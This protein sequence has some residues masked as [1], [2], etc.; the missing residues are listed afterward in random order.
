MRNRQHQVTKPFY[1]IVAGLVGTLLLSCLTGPSDTWKTRNAE[2]IQ[3]HGLK[4]R[5]RAIADVDVVPSLQPGKVYEFTDL[6]VID[7][8]SGVRATIA[9][10]RGA[11]VE[12]VEMAPGALYPEEI[13]RAELISVVQEGSAICVLDTG[14]LELSKNA[15]VY[16]TEGTKHSLRAGPNGCK[17]IEVFS[18]VRIDHLNLAG[19]ELSEGANTSFPDQTAEPSLQPGR[20]YDLN[21]IPFTPLTKDASA[22]SRLIWGKNAQLSFI[23]MDPSSSFPLHFHPEDQLMVTLQG[24]L[25]QTIIDRVYTLDGDRRRTLFLPGGMVH[26]AAISEF[27]AEAL[28]VFWPVRPDYVQYARKEA[29]SQR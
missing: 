7:I 5:E 1:C 20:V 25:D 18:P 2:I 11:L 24:E 29:A 19:A 10:G 21:Q 15:V 9:W 16:L 3:K 17:A 12:F 26:G 14:N 22:R 27:G 6:P 23:R 4:G 8:A 13:L 28:D